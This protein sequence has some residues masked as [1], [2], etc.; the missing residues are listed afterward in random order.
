MDASENSSATNDPAAQIA[1][2]QRQV[3]LQLLALIVVSGTLT[4]YLFYQSRIVSKDIDNVR[5]RAIQVIQT[6]NQNNSNMDYV[7]KQLAAYGQTHPDFQPILLK[8]EQAGL[9]RVSTNAAA[10]AAPKK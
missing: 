5:P 7:I 2:L 6:F 10:P 4:A 9:L 1:A 8:Y 3:F